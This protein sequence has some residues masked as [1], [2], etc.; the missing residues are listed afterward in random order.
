MTYQKKADLH[1]SLIS[2]FFDFYFP[3]ISS[4]CESGLKQFRSSST[5][6]VCLCFH[7]SLFLFMS[8]SCKTPFHARTLPY[9]T[10]YN[11]S[12]NSIE[13]KQAFLL[14]LISFSLTIAYFFK[15]FQQNFLRGG[16][17][18]IKMWNLKLCNLYVNY[19]H[20]NMTK[21]L[22][23]LNPLIVMVPCPKKHSMTG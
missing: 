18:N 20:N 9:K 2:F 17:G 16:Y 3:S 12:K 14:K 23:F 7:T 6:A 15:V 5:L 10:A 21:K 4:A 13:Q 22:L 8:V 19:L 1:F 11:R